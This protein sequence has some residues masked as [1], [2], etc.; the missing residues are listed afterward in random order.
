[1]GAIV[2]YCS[3]V[4]SVSWMKMWSDYNKRKTWEAYY[5]RDKVN[6]IAPDGKVVM[7]YVEDM[8]KNERLR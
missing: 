8:E 2:F 4:V 3:L 5:R 7:K 6:D 1:M